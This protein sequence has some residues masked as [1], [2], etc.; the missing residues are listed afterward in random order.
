MSKIRIA[1]VNGIWQLCMVVAGFQQSHQVGSQ[2]FLVI[3]TRRT[4]NQE[5]VQFVEMISSKFW[6][7]AGIILLD[8]NPSEWDKQ[9]QQDRQRAVQSVLS[10]FNLANSAAVDELWLCKIQFLD[11]RLF[12]DIFERA[13]IV[14]YEDG[15]HSYTEIKFLASLPNLDFSCPKSTV[16]QCQNFARN[17]LHKK[18]DWMHE[19]VKRSHLRRVQKFYSVLG[20]QIAIPDVLRGIAVEQI[21]ADGLKTLFSELH[22]QLNGSFCLDLPILPKK[23]ALLLGSNLSHLSTFPRELEVSVFADLAQCLEQQGY[24]ILWKEHPRSQRPL[25]EDIQKSLKSDAFYCLADE[26]K[27]PIEV[28]IAE[29]NIALCCS[30]L[31]SSLFYLRYIYGIQTASCVKPLLPYLKGDFYQLAELTLAKIGEL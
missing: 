27:M 30:T 17:I 28:L 2:D 4:G 26:Q 24:L 10:Q 23:T 15:L 12:A 14:L 16:V 31:S 29:A 21:K 22:H 7:W 6:N 13:Q 11:E 19:G 25:F 1:F 18:F 8:W 20:T 9:L 3:Y 5:L